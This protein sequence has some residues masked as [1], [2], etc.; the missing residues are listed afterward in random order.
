MEQLTLTLT[1]KKKKHGVNFLQR[2]GGRS[3]GDPKQ[4]GA[5]SRELEENLASRSSRGGAGWGHWWEKPGLDGLRPLTMSSMEPSLRL[6]PP[7]ERSVST[8]S[9]MFPS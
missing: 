7:W 9:C 8:V 2:N 4:K 1:R 5:T 3:L 6:L